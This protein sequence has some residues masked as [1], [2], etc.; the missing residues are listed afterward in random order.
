MKPVAPSSASAT[1]DI[2]LAR[3]TDERYAREALAPVGAYLT[4]AT[5]TLRHARSG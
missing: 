2:P 4:I 1:Y 3:T 5:A